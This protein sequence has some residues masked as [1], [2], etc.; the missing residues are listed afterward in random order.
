MKSI[1]VRRLMNK[2]ISA[3]CLFVGA[4][5]AQAQAQTSFPCQEKGMEKGV[6]A[7]YAGM[8]GGQLLM[9]GGCNFPDKPVAEGGKKHYYEGIYATSVGGPSFDWKRIGT[10]PEPAAYGLT[11]PVAHSLVLIGGNN[12]RG[13]ASCVQLSVEESGALKLDTLPSLPFS[14][15][16]MAGAALGDTLYIIGGNADGK[17][18]KALLSLSL[19]DL[20]GGWQQIAE[21][22]GAPRVQP[23]CAAVEGR[24]YVWGGFFA[25]GEQSEVATDG[26]SYDVETGQWQPL[27]S[28]TD[29]EGAPLTLSGGTA[30]AIGQKIVCTGGVNRS[31]FLDAISGRYQLTTKAD[32]LRHPVEWY[33]FNDLVLVFDTTTGRWEQPENRSAAFA[34]AGATA[35]LHDEGLYLVGGEVKPGVRTPTVVYL[36]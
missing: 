31:I 36:K 13:L 10:L 14:I 33:R 20:G 5:S 25:D 2:V 30:T 18:S 19:H 16:N 28:P 21:L 26:W 11:L 3:S 6:S 23:V 8:L 35:V 34:R 32:Y 4:V 27:P 9:A 22:P 1:N 17:P 7:C 29:R 15:D 24:L 12:E